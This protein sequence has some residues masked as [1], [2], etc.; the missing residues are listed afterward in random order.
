MRLAGLGNARGKVEHR[1]I[2]RRLLGR[3]GQLR[4]DLDDHVAR[5]QLRFDDPAGHALA[6]SRDGVV[7][8]LGKGPVQRQGDAVVGLIGIGQRA[9]T[10]H[11]RREFDM[12]PAKMG[13]RAHGGQ[14]ADIGLEPVGLSL[15]GQAEDV[16]GH[17]PF[18][19]QLG[20]VD[21]C[22]RA[23][24]LPRR[25][26]A[27]AIERVAENLR[28]GSGIGL[29][30]AIERGHRIELILARGILGEDA[31]EAGFVLRPGNC[32]PA[33]SFCKRRR[34]LAASTAM[35]A[36]KCPDSAALQRPLPRP[37]P[38]GDDIFH[39]AHHRRR[40]HAAYSRFGVA[41]GQGVVPQQ[42]QPGCG[43]R[44]MPSSE[45]SVSPPS[46]TSLR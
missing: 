20:P 42:Q 6:E 36:S 30:A 15:L 28:Q 3:L 2:E 34:R 43:G 8:H 37:E 31:A 12:Q 44:P 41:V 16:V 18:R 14:R 4:I 29:L 26:E 11:Q 46:S 27:A 39:A 45:N 5:R 1:R 10:G 23:Q 24:A 35:A 38:L 25:G 22:Q 33:C 7:E 21:P 40:R 19:A 13:E 32:E 9:A 17:L